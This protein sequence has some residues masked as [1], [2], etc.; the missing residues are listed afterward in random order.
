[1]AHPRFQAAI[2]TIHSIFPKDLNFIADCM[3]VS[4]LLPRSTGFTGSVPL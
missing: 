2:G 1:M 4:L 3:E